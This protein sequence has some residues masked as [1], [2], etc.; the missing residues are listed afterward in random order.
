MARRSLLIY[1]TCPPSSIFATMLDYLSAQH[2]TLQ[3]KT[4]IQCTIIWRGILILYPS[5]ASTVRRDF[6]RS[7]HL[8]F[9]LDQGMLKAMSLLQSSHANL[10]A[11][12]SVQWQRVIWE[13]I[14]SVATFRRKPI[15]FAS[16]TLMELSVLNVRETL[17][18]RQHSIIIAWIALTCQAMIFVSQC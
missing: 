13:H 1:K 15:N 6:C 8:I 14:V 9:I 3:R 2:V 16:K 18:Q 5:L 11:V 12:N 4:K 17:N 7:L 10:T